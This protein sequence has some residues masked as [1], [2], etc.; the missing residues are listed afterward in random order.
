MSYVTHEELRKVLEA[1]GATGNA[2]LASAVERA[3]ASLTPAPSEAKCEGF[4]CLHGFPAPADCSQI[5]DGRCARVVG[6][7]CGLPFPAH[8]KPAAEPAPEYAGS[9]VFQSRQAQARRI[10]AALTPAPTTGSA[11]WVDHLSI[12]AA[13]VAPVRFEDRGGTIF[14][15]KTGLQWEKAT[16]NR[17]TW[18]Q[19][20]D[21]KL[22]LDGHSDWRLPTIEELFSIVDFERHDPACDPVFAA[23]SDFYWSSSTYQGTPTG[24]WY[25]YFSSGDTNALLKTGGYYVRAVRAG[26]RN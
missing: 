25:V 5:C 23:Q 18:Q 4:V 8:H 17:M 19:A 7:R 15:H 13:E 9:E 2:M 6:A 1:M 12:T 14:D 26:K 11:H 16:G 22:T 10:N 20:M 21:R 24:A 3:I